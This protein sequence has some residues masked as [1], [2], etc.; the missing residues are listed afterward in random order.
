MPARDVAVVAESGDAADLDEGEAGCLG[1]A[2]EPH[3]SDGRVVVVRYRLA[4]RGGAGWGPL[5]S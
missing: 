3:P 5:R 2:D 1:G 4:A